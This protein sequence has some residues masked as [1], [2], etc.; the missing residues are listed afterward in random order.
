MSKTLSLE[1]LLAAPAARSITKRVEIPEW[2]G[3]MVLCALSEAK[4]QQFLRDAANAEKDET[5]LDMFEVSLLA[6]CIVEPEMSLEAARQLQ[7]KATGVVRYLLSEI[8]DLSGLTR[9]GSISK[10]AVEQAEKSF[11]K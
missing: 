6:N 4:R 11:R 1:E 10:R 2:G 5:N 8:Y 3:S 9:L 7:E